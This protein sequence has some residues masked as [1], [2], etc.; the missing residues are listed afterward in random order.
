MAFRANITLCLQ[1]IKIII[2]HYS[3]TFRA[4]QPLF[5]DRLYGPTHQHTP[6]GKVF[7]PLIQERV[8]I[9]SIN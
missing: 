3:Q 9:E 2:N 8:N 6:A 4:V 5:R 1:G 7:S